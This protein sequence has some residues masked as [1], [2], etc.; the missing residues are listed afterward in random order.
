MFSPGYI[1][2]T[3]KSLIPDSF[4]VHRLPSSAGNAVILT[5]D[6]GPDEKITPRILEQLEEYNVHAVFFVIGEKVAMFPNIFEMIVQ[7]GHTIGNHT[8]SHHYKKIPSF[9]VY[10]RDIIR[11]QQIIEEKTGNKPILYRPPAGFIS[12]ITLLLARTQGLKTVLW[13]NEGGEWGVNKQDTASTIGNRLINTLQPRDIVLLHDNNEKVPFIMEMILP[14]LKNRSI[15]L[16][17]G[18]HAICP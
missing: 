17:H 13:S 4:L 1:K 7:R 6:D 14:A 11:C 12:P 8:Y 15:D 9:K 2:N 3:I 18:V 5:F 16:Q 10:L